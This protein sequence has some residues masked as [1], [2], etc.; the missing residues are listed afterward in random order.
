M[1]R[2]ISESR[3][4]D[5]LFNVI[6]EKV[7]KGKLIMI[8][9]AGIL[10]PITSLP[11]PYGVGT[12]GKAAREFIDFLADAGQTWWQ[13]LPV[14]PTGYGNSPY[15]AL[16]SYA[17]STYLIDLD[18]LVSDGLLKKEEIEGI[19]WGKDPEHVDYGILY[20][21]RNRLLHKATERLALKHPKEYLE[22]L[23]QEYSWLR[24]YAVFMAV[25]DHEK[26]KPWTQWPQA[27]HRHDSEEVR[28]LA[29]ECR[30]E[31]IF[32]ER[33]QYLFYRQMKAMK[34]YA[35][36]S[37]IQIIGDLPFYIAADSIDVWSHPEQFE[38]NEHNEM[39]F[40]S[41]F[42]PDGGNPRGQKW[43]NPLFSW[44]KMKQDNYKWWIDR[45]AYQAKLYDMIRIDHF[46]GYSTYFAIPANDEDALR[47]HWRKGPGLE[48]FRIMEEK[49]GK[50]QI[51]VEDLGQL[52][53]EFMAMVRESGYPGM[54]ILQYAFD[55]NDP[56]SVYMPF[57]YDHNSVVYTG[58]HDNDTLTGWKN[59]KN[60][61]ARIQ[62]AAEYLG[63][64]EEEGFTWGML[65][66]AYS[67]TSDLAII[68][69][70]DLLELGSE[71]RF[72]D[73]SGK[74][75]AWTWRCRNNVFTPALAAK[76]KEKMLLYCRNNWQAKHPSE[77]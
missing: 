46:Q 45:M 33:V 23:R 11:S 42:A 15:Q 18:D 14:G 24:D 40:V 13:I 26:G 72:N 47:G 67:S 49:L 64:N 65:R 73:P 34:K 31:V 9:S 62:R 37:G 48:L 59:D 29:E 4:A 38:M 27:L 35:N 44:E 10:L 52:T 51:I 77:H 3:F 60:Q 43:G 1:N 36:D 55:P 17:G 8:R 7:Y 22:F 71:A 56:G 6:I 16:S 25:K 2:I 58:T 76:L 30:E 66:A 74:A 69:M 53:P 20:N 21:E 68:Q 57:Q 12:M 39:T 61:K 63:L 70:Q 50:L 41:G 54:K 28:A 5:S 32:Y 75:P 19:V